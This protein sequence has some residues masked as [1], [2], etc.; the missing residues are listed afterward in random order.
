MWSVSEIV[1]NLTAPVVFK[2]RPLAVSM[3][4]STFVVIP[5]SRL[6]VREKR[7]YELKL[8]P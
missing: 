1:A 3:G 4:F 2:G 7:E 5:K 8:A 6:S